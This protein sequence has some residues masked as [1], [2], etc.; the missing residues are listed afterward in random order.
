MFA[1]HH[2]LANL[3]VLVDLNGSQALGRTAQVLD[4]APMGERWRAFGWDVHDVDGH[5]P[6]EISATIA[7]FAAPT[8]ADR[9]HILIAHTTFGKGA[10][11]MEDQ[12]AWHYLPLSDAN[13]AQAREEIAKATQS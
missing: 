7:T 13:Y 4:L 3:I 1:A 5:N 8:A 9:P 11:F 6:A 2:H 12:F 10:S